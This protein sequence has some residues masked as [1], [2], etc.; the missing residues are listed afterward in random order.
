[1]EYGNYQCSYC[2]QA[3]FVVKELQEL[4]GHGLR[5]VFRNFPLTGVHPHAEHAAEAAETAAAQGK[6]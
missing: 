5:V 2:G 4:L 3:Y 6:F 1:V